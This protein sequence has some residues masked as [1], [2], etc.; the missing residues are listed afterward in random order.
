MNG[1]WCRIPL[2][3][4][5]LGVHASG[6]AVAQYVEMPPPSRSGRPVPAAVVERSLR[7]PTALWLRGGWVG[8]AERAAAA[9]QPVA[10]DLPLVVVPALFADSPEPHVAAEAL[11]QA[12][13]TGPAAEGTLREYYAEISGGR[14][15]IA[16]DATSWVRTS[17]TREEVVGSQWGLGGDAR[18]GEYLV[19]ALALNDPTVDFGQFDNDGPDNIPNSGDDNGVVDAIAFYFLEVAASCGGPGIWPHFWSIGAAAGQPFE[20]DD[21]R[22]DGTPV[23]IDPYFI[24]SIVDCNGAEIAPVTTIA[25][26]LGHLLGLPDLYHPVDGL[27]PEQR[28]WVEGCWSLMAAGAWGCGAVDQPRADWKRP[29]HMG[30]WEK[31]RLGWL[32]QIDQLGA[33]ELTEY[34]LPAVQ[35]SGRILELPLGHAERLL[36]EY[37]DRIGF[38]ADL[39]AAGV[40]VHRVNDTIPWRPCADCPPIYQVMLLEADGDSALVETH[41]Q[42]GD[43][44]APGDAYG[45]LGVGALTS[46][47]QPSSRRNAGLGDESGVNIYEVELGTGGARLLIST[48][49]ISLP[50]LL[51]P[52]LQDSGN[53]LTEAEQGFLDQLNN[54]NGRYDVG[55]VRAY[56]HR[57][58]TVE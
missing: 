1:V 56:L 36:I 49:P 3:V 21:L 55:D 13:F 18:V 52:L 31:K 8:R 2:L 16:G 19:E 22:P 28:R 57:S 45:A 43:R 54:G 30:A 41:P 29:T 58:G 17:L 26:E 40:L 20:T 12:L 35:T 39:P 5:G 51:G 6:F 34:T 46:L 10:G 11:R 23:R 32:D 4:A 33:T 53:P 37:R 27:L 25:H 48:G 15:N 14:L 50:R 7:P 47:T 42:G 24:Q 44:G 9:A 38:D